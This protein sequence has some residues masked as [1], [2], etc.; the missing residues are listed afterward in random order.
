MHCEVGIRIFTDSHDISKLHSLPRFVSVCTAA[1][2]TE[3]RKTYQRMRCGRI[4]T[5][6]KVVLIEH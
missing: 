1:G 2:D 6:N 3:I 4:L 5:Q